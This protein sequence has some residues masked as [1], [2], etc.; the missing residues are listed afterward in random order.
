MQTFFKKHRAYGEQVT[1]LSIHCIEMTFEQYVSLPGLFPNVKSFIVYVESFSALKAKDWN[2]KK[3]QEEFKQRRHTIEEIQEIGAP[4]CTN[5]LLTRTVCKTLVYLNISTSGLAKESERNKFIPKLKFA[6]NLTHLHIQDTSFK[7]KELENLLTV[8]PNLKVL[9]FT[10]VKF[11]FDLT[12]DMKDVQPCQLETLIISGGD[13]NNNIIAV[14]R[15]L[16]FFGKKF[17]HLKNYIHDKMDD[18][19]IVQGSFE[20]FG[21]C[22]GQNFLSK[23]TH[24]NFY[25]C[26]HLNW[27]QKYLK[28]S[29]M[30]EFN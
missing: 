3:A 28:R 13:F 11:T 12:F 5:G 14:K 16:A 17:I 20:E 24:W 4:I 29:M 1:D 7:M 19:D 21:K 30:L 25:V 26:M 10:N 23:L 2:T 27:I 6:P 18:N 15:W 22:L 9:D 8:K